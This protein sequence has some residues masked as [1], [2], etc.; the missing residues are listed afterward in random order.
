MA[1]GAALSP[2][3]Y[4]KAISGETGAAFQALRKAVMQAGPLD[5][6][7]CEL[8]ALGGLVTSGSEQSFKTHARRLLRE[9]VAGAALRQAVLVTFGASTTFSQVLAGLQWVE[10]LEK[11]LS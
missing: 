7:T 9:G 10:Q 5:K 11:E 8:I 3:D 1:E 2:I 4:L 6:H